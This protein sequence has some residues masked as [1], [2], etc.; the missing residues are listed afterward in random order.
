MAQKYSRRALNGALP[1]NLSAPYSAG[2]RN[3]V[4]KL[5]FPIRMGLLGS[6]SFF[7][8]GYFAFWRLFFPGPLPLFCIYL[9]VFQGGC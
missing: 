6:G 7:A 1:T 2:E 4:Y 3:F 9:S 8:F 5:K